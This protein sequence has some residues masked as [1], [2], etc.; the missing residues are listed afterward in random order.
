MVVTQIAVSMVLLVG[1]LLFVRSYRNL[2]TVS[3]GFRENRITIAGFGLAPSKVK[4]DQL[5]DYKRQLVDAVRATPG[6]ENAAATTVI[7][8]AGD[9]WE[10]HVEVGSVDGPSKFTYVSPTFFATLGIP[11]VEGR[12]FTDY[13]TNMKP[14]VLVVNQAFVRKY[15]GAR[16]PLGVPVRVRPEPSYP[17]RT[18][19]IVGV[20]SDTKY[21][22]LRGEPPPQAFVP[23]AQ[24][25]VT[26]QGRGIAMLIAS[27]RSRCCAD[28]RAP[29]AEPGVSRHGRAIFRFSAGHPR[30]AGG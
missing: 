11:V 26:A 19:Q 2:L 1:A 6:V 29:H 5:A 23:I 3:P 18:C 14:L 28:G 7:P 22:D 4:M 13:D 30:P 15:V 25:P 16:S 9:D 8:L 17:A 20:V 10:H 12:N 24:L 21:S 27:G